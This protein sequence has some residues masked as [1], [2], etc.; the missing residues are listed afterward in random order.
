MLQNY[1]KIAF[2]NLYRNKLYSA[3]NIIGFALGIAC[4]LAIMLWVQYEWSFN[5]FHSKLDRI[6]SV[7]R[8]QPLLGEVKV[9]SSISG[10][11]A[12]AAMSDI[13]QIESVVQVS[14][15]QNVFAVKK[16]IFRAQ[17]VFS[18]SAIFTMFDFP[19]LAG[20]PAIALDEPNSVALSESLARK[21]FGSVD[22]ASIIGKT[23]RADAAVDCKVS[24]VFRDIPKN[25]TLRF[26]YAMSLK[27]FIQN[28]P[29]AQRWDN[30]WFRTFILLR[31]GSTVVNV[32]ADL[33]DI[34][35]RKG[36][37]RDGQILFTQPFA[38]VHLYN[39]FQSGVTQSGK[40]GGRIET[41]QLFLTI[42]GIVLVLACVNFMNLSTAQSVGRSKEIGIRKSVGAARSQLIAQSLGESVLMALVALP[43]ALLLVEI[44]LP[45]MNNLLG[46]SLRIPFANALFWLVLFAFGIVVG[47][48][49]GLYPAFIL[50]SFATVNI[51]K[52]TM[53]SGPRAVL[54]R[55]G[56]VVAEFAVAV[57]FIAG[58]LVVVQQ[59]EFIKTKNLG[60][61]RENVI[62]FSVNI[63]ADRFA[64]WK[65]EMKSQGVITSIAGGDA[66]SPLQL[67]SST[68]AMHWKGQLPNEKMNIF[69]LH[70][71]NDFISLLGIHIK[72]GRGFSSTFPADTANYIINETCARAMHLDNPVGETL[73][74][75]SGQHSQ[76]GIIVGVVEDF[77]FKSMHDAIEP[78][79]FTYGS[80]PSRVFVRLA[81]GRIEEGLS[82]LRSSF[83]QYQPGLPFTYQFLDEEF[84]E[85]YKSE[86]MISR[87]ALVFAGLAIAIC[88]L[89]LF[90]LSVFTAESRT[91]EI[92]VRKVLGASAASIIRLLN[93]DFLLL[94]GIAIVI[95]LPIAWY[96]MNAWL[97]DFAYRVD[98]GAGVF[99]LAG[100]MAVLIAFATVASQAWRAAR[101]NPVHAL[102]SE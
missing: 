87:L 26:E 47:V 72:A 80:T 10:A 95:A 27:Q 24:A 2:R 49:A 101:A 5:R 41:V 50:S 19:L 11:F 59:L 90:G 34:L 15:E 63:P 9:S 84:A 62:S 61:N 48:L 77:H 43:L 91:K 64:T 92:G 32:N 17:G 23:V 3:M 76:I 67:H 65:N 45:A 68:S 78:M 39:D 44:A 57:A 12:D 46:E 85:M 16:N 81:D 40:Q 96:S 4:C 6:H 52:G 22:V 54:F 7:M 82:V 18:Y 60:L 53:K 69:H 14:E 33:K 88:C 73:R 83:A 25:S 58:A 99:V 56:L 75:G 20:N 29:G 35:A 21:L 94:V 74:W 1:L 98:L 38:E 42:A 28:N 97:Q 102:R 89:G 55:R 31:E 93:K 37:I 66:A 86:T 8:A 13:P 71:D 70:G 30:A 51:L 100:A 36:N 79:M